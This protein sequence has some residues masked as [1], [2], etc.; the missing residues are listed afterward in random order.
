MTCC[1]SA[2]SEVAERNRLFD[3]AI[4]NMSQGMCLYDAQQRI[5]FANDRYAEIYGLTPEQAKPGTT[6]R[7]VFA[8]RAAQGAFW[9]EPGG[10][11]HPRRPGALRQ[12]YVRDSRGWT[13]GASSLSCGARCRMAACSARTRTL[14]E[15]EQLSSRITRQNEL[16]I[17]REQ[18]LNVRNEQLDAALNNMLQG[19]AMYDSKFQL[20]ICNRRYAEMYGLS[21]EQVKRGTPLRVIM[22]HRIARGEFRGKSADE[23]VE[24][25]VKRVAGQTTAQYVNE[26]CDGRHISVST[27]RA[28][29]MAV[30]S[31]RTTTSPSSAARRPRS[32][33][34]RC[35]T[36]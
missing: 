18:E 27:R 36:R 21:P 3:A 31:R 5:V 25:R 24:E 6:L 13:M 19:L 22:E 8:A 14:R 15:R 35:T 33:T 7:E 11:I 28:C 23:L 4:S 12:V 26:L 34:W 9:G 10:G 30:P 2:K 16:L 20:V 17:E 1:S 32:R 29:Q